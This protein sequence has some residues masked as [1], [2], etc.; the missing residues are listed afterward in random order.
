MNLSNRLTAEQIVEIERL[1]KTE[2]AREQ[3][4]RDEGQSQLY[5]YLY[6]VLLKSPST[7]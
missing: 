7:V 6:E 3:R 2:R 4:A 5:R 1:T